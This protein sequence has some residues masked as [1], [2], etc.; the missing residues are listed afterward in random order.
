MF[1]TYILEFNEI[2]LFFFLNAIVSV[3]THQLWLEIEI[4][5]DGSHDTGD[6]IGD[7]LNVDIIIV[8]EKAIYFIIGY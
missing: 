6:G 2:P 1:N 5:N 3:R 8:S 4:I 7:I